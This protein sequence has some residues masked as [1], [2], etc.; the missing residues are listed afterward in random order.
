[1]AAAILKPVVPDF[2][3][4]SWA[5]IKGF[6]CGGQTGIRLARD[7]EGTGGTGFVHQAVLQDLPELCGHQVMP[8]ARQLW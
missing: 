4:S 2:R 3:L 5:K 7:V 8:V 6:P 1:M